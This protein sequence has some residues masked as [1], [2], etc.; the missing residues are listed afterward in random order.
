MTI[1]RLTPADVSAYRR[2]RLRGLRECP[3][4]FGSSYAEEV[5]RPR[6]AF[7][8]R[9]A[10]TPARW[11]LGAFEAG[12]LVGVLSLVRETRAK[13]K[14]KAAIYGMYVERPSRRTGIGRAL[15]AHALATARQLRG[16]RQVR[17][18]VVA[19]NLAARRLYAAAGFTVYG[20]E[21]AA[22]FVAGRYHAELFLVR[23]LRR[24]RGM[25][26]RRIWG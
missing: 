21:A 20:R 17:L 6:A 14:H 2:I 22:L 18:A 9:L 1:R 26:G 25:A 5:K 15:V 19:S 23:R 3:A 8:H 10:Q 11:T 16:L 13:E 7:A 24:G 4:A 12:R